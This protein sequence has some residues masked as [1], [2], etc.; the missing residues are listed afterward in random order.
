MNCNTTNKMKEE[1]KKAIKSNELKISW[2]LAD[3]IKLEKQ[4]SKNNLEID[5][6]IRKNKKLK[7]L[8]GEK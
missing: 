4:L 3:N 5:S 8:R 2:I 7:K 1:F 6:L